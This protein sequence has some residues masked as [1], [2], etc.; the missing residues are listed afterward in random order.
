MYP[1]CGQCHAEVVDRNGGSVLSSHR[2]EFER[3]RRRRHIPVSGR[4]VGAPTLGDLLE[5]HSTSMWQSI[6]ITVNEL[7]ARG[8][9]TS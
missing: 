9:D 6:V 5:T 4:Q 8:Q 7:R 2:A 1:T 3:G